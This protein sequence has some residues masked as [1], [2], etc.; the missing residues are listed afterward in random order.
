MGVPAGS[1]GGACGSLFGRSETRCL[2]LSGGAFLPTFRTLE[3]ILEPD[4][5]TWGE[6]IH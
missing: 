4:W 3:K 5:V 2:D 1:L 6:E